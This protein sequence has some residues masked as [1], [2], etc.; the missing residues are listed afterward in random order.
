[1]EIQILIR[2]Y[3]LLNAIKFNGQARL[4]PSIAALFAENPE[5][6]SK[7]KEIKNMTIAVVEDVNRLSLD[8]QRIEIE[9]SYPELLEI[10]EKEKEKIKLPPLPNA[11]KYKLIVTRFAPAPTGALHIS[12]L[13]R[14]LYLSYSYAKIYNGKFI[15]RYEDTDPNRIDPVFYDWIAEDL[16]AVEMIWDEI[17]YESDHF[18]LYLE[19]AEEL[20]EKGRI[21]VDT[22][23][24]E[25]FREYKAE[26]RNCPHRLLSEE[27]QIERW[28]KMLNGTFAEGEAV[29]R[30]KA[31]M[32]DKN[33]VLRDPPLL[34]IVDTP[35]PRTGTK[36]RVYPLYNYA[37]TIEDHFSRITHVLRAKEHEHNATIQE[38]LYED[39]GWNPPE[40]IQFGMVYLP[41]PLGK[42]H[43]REI[44]QW[45]KEGKISGWDD[46]RLPTIRAFLRRGF[47]PDAF[48]ELA[49]ATGLS[50][51]DIRLS[52]DTLYA[53]NRKIIDPLANRYFFVDP[54]EIIVE[55]VPNTI[56]A[57]LI[58]LHP[59]FPERGNRKLLVNKLN[60]KMKI[61]LDKN[62]VQQLAEQELL[63]LKDLFN[64][65]IENI[66][67]G[68]IAS[69]HSKEVD[70]I[71]KEKRKII[72]WLPVSEDLMKTQ[73][74]MPDGSI[75]AGFS[76][77]TKGMIKPG[78]I[79]QFE[80]IGFGRV[81]QIGTELVVWF[82]HK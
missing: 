46:I 7:A 78:D 54:V 26:M 33:P 64:I 39:F 17:V 58:P 4:G 67:N 49:I 24:Q 72:Q 60:Q 59:E 62:D 56:N 53:F 12:H 23:T 21:Y 19:K 70:I 18:D 1:M 2:K 40:A 9:K 50:K 6:K 3:V 20:I 27:E 11:E 10:K 82:A 55:D 41:D 52:L 65:K 61:Y 75:L 25:E 35:H 38:M 79:I 51:T 42:I 77:P 16:K 81:D 74:I 63:R 15:L 73:I 30:K 37:N 68:P 8:E 29:V 47:Q 5:L 57:A 71:L 80:R 28:S 44:R 32:D 14:A 13:L 43:K 76:E 45:L 36:Y 48:K 34:R 69:F 66:D 31:R 22:C